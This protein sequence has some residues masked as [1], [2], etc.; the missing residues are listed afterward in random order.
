[1]KIP[2]I[3]YTGLNLFKQYENRCDLYVDSIKCLNIVEILQEF[4]IN[5]KN[6]DNFQIVNSWTSTFISVNEYLIVIENGIDDNRK[7]TYKKFN[8][9]IKKISCCDE[10]SLILLENGSLWKMSLENLEIKEL[11]FLNV[12]KPIKDLLNSIPDYITDI[13]CSETF[14]VATTKKGDIYNI[15]TKLFTLKNNDKVKKI[16][17]GMEHA[18]LVNIVDAS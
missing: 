6:I 16:C 12:E 7:S 9:N 15:P 10:Y 1:M 11:T 14:S 3:F 18:V 4:D 8:E 13:A 2:K 17:C 5:C